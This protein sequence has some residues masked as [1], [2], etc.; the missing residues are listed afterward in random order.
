MKKYTPPVPRSTYLD[1]EFVIQTVHEFIQKY[2]P[3]SYHKDALIAEEFRDGVYEALLRE[4]DLYNEPEVMM[5][6]LVRGY[7]WEFTQADWDNIQCFDFFVR[8]KI[9]EKEEQWVKDNNIM[10]P[11]PVG[12]RVRLPSHYKETTGVID[13]IYEYEPARYCVL[14]D[15]QVEYNKQMEQQG[16][17]MRHG[18]YVLRFEDVEL[19]E[20][21]RNV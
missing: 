10:P 20:D 14:T 13:R 16:E 12:A 1:Q 11:F 17:T 7:Y 4:F 5:D 15:K 2:Y 19:V 8:E 3:S 6:T 18:G 21:C 9:K